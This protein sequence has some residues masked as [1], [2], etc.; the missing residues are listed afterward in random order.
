MWEDVRVL[1]IE[2]VSMIGLAVY[3]MMDLLGAHGCSSARDVSD[4]IDAW[5]NHNFG[6]GPIVFHR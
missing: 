1:I 3:N 5:E 4:A 6:G 2:E